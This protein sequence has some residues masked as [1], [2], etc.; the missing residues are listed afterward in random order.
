MAEEAHSGPRLGVLG[1]PVNHSRSPAMQNAALAAV[2]LTSWRYQLLPVPPELFAETVRGLAEVGFVGANVTIPHKAAALALADEPS[3]RAAAIGAVNTLL[4][5]RDGTIWADNTDGPGLVAALADRGIALRDLPVQVLGAGGTGRAA[6]WALVD[7]GADVRV[8]NR[9]PDRAEQLCAELGGRAVREPEPA[10]LLIQASAAGL[11]ERNHLPAFKI[12]AENADALGRFEI[13]V[14]FVYKPD[15]GA[16][17][18]AAQ[19]QGVAVIDGLE[20][21]VRQGA[22][23]FE[24]F[25][26]RPAPFDVMNRS[27]RA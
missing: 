5:R 25:T 18:R 16:L 26:G 4:F 24:L 1:W 22:L 9:T 27:V 3:L 13:V 23:S 15:G 21:L 10:A 7:A 17:L 19:R 12:L 2:G 14:D 11:T 20:L 8:W 6:V